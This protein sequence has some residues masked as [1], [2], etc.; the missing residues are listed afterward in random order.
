MEASAGQSC[1]RSGPPMDDNNNM[2]HRNI[3]PYDDTVEALHI[4]T[5]LIIPQIAYNDKQKYDPCF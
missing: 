3:K 4:F 2:L 5:V 1:C